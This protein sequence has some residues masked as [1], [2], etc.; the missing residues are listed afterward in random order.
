MITYH[1]ILKWRCTRCSVSGEVTLDVSDGV[2]VRWNRVVLAHA[3]VSP[4][5]SDEWGEGGIAVHQVAD[6]LPAAS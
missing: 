3:E 4:L 2:D 5:C 6:T 1:P